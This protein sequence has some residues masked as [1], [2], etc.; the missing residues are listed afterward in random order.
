[1]VLSGELLCAEVS[2]VLLLSK[3]LDGAPIFGIVGSYMKARKEEE[4]GS[5]KT[6]AGESGK[7]GH[8]CCAC[9]VM[10]PSF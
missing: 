2:S 10:L 5:R 3:P 9:T 8:V 1:M 6:G 4:A 7:Y